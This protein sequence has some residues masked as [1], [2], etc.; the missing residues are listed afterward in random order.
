ME[1]TV[2]EK[3]WEQLLQL[4]PQGTAK[5][6]KCGYLKDLN[7]YCVKFMG[8]EYTVDIGEKQI[9]IGSEDGEPVGAGFME[10]LCILAYLIKSVKVPL[11]K[12]LV[13]GD[14]LESGEFFFRGPHVIPTAK[15]EDV[16]GYNPDLIYSATNGMNAKKASF[17]DASVEVRVFDRLPVTFVVWGADDEFPARGSILFDQSATSHLPLDA[18]LAAVDITVKSLISAVS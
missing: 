15:L 2:H 11:S 12:R 3:L 17:G 18:L 1:I 5:R 13:T 9:F 4:D 7:Q 8:I 16:F 6:V 10:Q 14:K